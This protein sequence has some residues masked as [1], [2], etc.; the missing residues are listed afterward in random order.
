VPTTIEDDQ[1]TRAFGALANGTRRAIVARL[2]EGEATVKHIKVLE[3]AGLVRRAQRAQFRPCVLDTAALEQVST[4]AQQTRRV[5]DERLDRMD[6][7]LTRLGKSE[8]KRKG[9]R[10]R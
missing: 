4:W 10:T 7:H 9:K 3:Q 6:E 2:A 8:A 5:W 1:L